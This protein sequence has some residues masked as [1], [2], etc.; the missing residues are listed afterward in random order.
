MRESSDK[1]A[2]F[3]RRGDIYHFKLPDGRHTYAQHV[4]LFSEIWNLIRV[5]NYVDVHELESLDALEEKGL[6]FPP[7]FSNVDRPLREGRWRR[8]GKRAVTNFTFR[9]FVI[10]LAQSRGPTSAGT[11]G[12][13][14]KR[15]VSGN[16]GRDE[17]P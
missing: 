12:T 1:G 11:S 9:S 13:E 16:V 15:R 2:S 10:Y 7:V 17:G 5:F 14:R 4:A 8:I 3:T 6:L